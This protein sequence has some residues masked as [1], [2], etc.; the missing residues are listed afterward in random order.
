MKLDKQS[1]AYRL[2]LPVF[3]VI[4]VVSLALV[5]LVSRISSHIIDEYFQ[6]TLA[7]Y[8]AE[9][10]RI[11]DTALAELSTARLLDN[12]MVVEVKQ[13]TVV[14]ALSL[15]WKSRNLEGIV[16]GPDGKVN[17][18][19]LSADLTGRIIAIPATGHFLVADGSRELHGQS[20]FYP[21]WEWRV[22]TLTS[23][24]PTHATRN[25]VL[26]LVPLVALGSFCMFA[27]VFVILQRRLQRPVAMMVSDVRSG[28]AASLTGVTEFDRIGSAIND[29]LKE[30]NE[31]TAAVLARDERI[32]LL[33]ASTAEGIFGVDRDGTCTFCN[34]AALAMLGYTD[35]Q[36]MLGKNTHDL[37]HHS[38]TDGSPYPERDC[39]I[40]QAYQK[41]L[42]VHVDDEVFWR[43]DGSSFPTEYWSYPVSEHGAI[44]GSV[45]T[46]I[47]ISERRKADAALREEKN[48]IEAIIAA[49][50]EGL[51]IQDRSFR[52]LYQNDV[53]KGFVGDHAGELCYEAYEFKKTP[54]EGCPVSLAFNDGKIHAVEWVVEKPGAT[55]YYE[56]T[57]SPL[58]DASGT[59]VAGIEL[60]RDATERRRTEQQLQQAQKMEAIG[61]LAGGIAHDFN[62]VLTAIVGYASLLKKQAGEGSQALFFSEQILASAYR[63]TNL[64]RQILAFSRKQVI[65][66]QPASLND[67]IRGMEKFLGRLL[68]EDVEVR[69]ALTSSNV[70]ALVD[71]GQMEQVV[72]N[73]ATNAR[74]AMPSGGLLLIGTD[75]VDLNE[76]DAIRY[77]LERAGSYALLTVSDAG[78]GMDERT[79]ARIFEPFFTT[80]AM[81]RGTGLG[82]AIVYGIIKQHNGHVTVYS[83]PDKGTTFKIYLPL[84]GS[85]AEMREASI[86]AAVRGGSET[87]LLA[88][89]DPDVQ[90]Y[91]KRVLE[92]NG[93]TVLIAV[94]GNDAV[95]AFRERPDAIGLCLFDVI[96]P[97]KNGRAAFQEIRALRNSAKAI[98]MSGYAADIIREKDLLDKN[99]VLMNKP[100]LPHDLLTR[101][102][103]VLDS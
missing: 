57:A 47:D 62:N 84:T 88:E 43:K 92:E 38:R 32:R 27:V 33:L 73:L 37:F 49:M 20:F 16:I 34:P 2:L 30:V 70:T 7:T 100:I 4:V 81:G 19:T 93:Y 29:A 91:F 69:T 5:V 54:C 31:R 6:T 79:R 68:G 67:I 90:G 12:P 13:R 87:I 50:G 25:E 36:H 39:R 66:P 94:D 46:F 83:E 80:K 86:E 89:D 78:T 101:V 51:S 55:K 26:Y 42:K 56:I 41:N 18:S 35:E 22:L 64:T 9:S 53:H 96:M 52:V 15:N 44:T 97:K 48:K 60:V 17:F 82:L 3:A 28:Q 11:L 71:A 61:Q 8:N 14:E 1:L 74:D 65:R 59:I 103:E 58:R 21:A 23:S 99:M 45:V 77:G 40:F 102:R 24:M 85:R 63:A 75:V 10:K 95:N 72:M 76:E 98:F